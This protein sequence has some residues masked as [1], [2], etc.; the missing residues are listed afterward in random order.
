VLP[1]GWKIGIVLGIGVAIATSVGL[2]YRHYSGLVDAKAE[3]SAQVARLEK[4]VARE[5]SR[6]DA[7]EQ[8]IAKWDQASKVQAAALE[9]LTTARRDASRYRRELL[10]VLSRH[11]LEALARA[12][13]GLVQDRIN[14]GSARALRLLEQ[15][16]Q[17]PGPAAAPEPGPTGAGAGQARGGAVEGRAVTNW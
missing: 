3:L 15:S 16:T 17:V 7:L 11:D 2:A 12:K 6:A 13:P 8:S 5:K 4:D 9:E 14:A 10:D 1:V